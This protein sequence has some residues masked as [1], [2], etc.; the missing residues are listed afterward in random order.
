MVHLR[1][2]DS[3]CRF[4]PMMF[5]SL[6]TT[7]LM[8]IAFFHVN[9]CAQGVVWFAPYSLEEMPDM[10]PNGLIEITYK[11]WPEEI[12]YGDAFF[13]SVYVTNI[14]EEPVSFSISDLFIIK[15]RSLSGEAVRLFGRPDCGTRVGNT[16]FYYYFAHPGYSRKLPT[17]E[18]QPNET[19][20]V[21]IE[22]FSHNVRI[23]D[24]SKLRA[25]GLVNV[26]I[27]NFHPELFL[28]SQ[29]EEPT[30][31]ILPR[32]IKSEEGLIDRFHMPNGTPL[33]PPGARFDTSVGHLPIGLVF[34][35]GA[36]SQPPGTF[37]REED[38]IYDW[39]GMKTLEQGFSAGTYRD[40]LRLGRIILQYVDT[41]D[42]L[43]LKELGDWFSEMPEVQ[44]TSYS[45][46]Q[47]ERIL[48]KD[49][50]GE[51]FPDNLDERHKRMFA[52]YKHIQ[53]FDVLPFSDEE[54]AL[55]KQFGI[56]EH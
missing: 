43:V 19:K 21:H 13:L 32:K 7:T 40:E 23:R 27:I 3:N 18:I 8:T 31:R 17:I 34:T 39:Q 37:Q 9:A 52:L 20:R 11:V 45:R 4:L 22:H 29:P 38:V 49:F 47:R 10:L 44:R 54:I 46:M 50:L 51:H 48:S 6:L 30:I 53:E 16:S 56:I 26:R 42:P 14:S 55:L 24:G 2:V 15:G 12:Q 36:I 1:E 25:P 28:P 35:L 5:H 33:R 41:N